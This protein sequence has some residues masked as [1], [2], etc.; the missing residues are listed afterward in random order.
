MGLI[1]VFFIS[2][3]SCSQSHVLARRPIVSIVQVDLI[4][5]QKFYDIFDSNRRWDL[6]SFCIPSLVLGDWLPQSRVGDSLG[7]AARYSTRPLI[8]HTAMRNHQDQENRT[9][10]WVFARFSNDNQEEPLRETPLEIIQKRWPF[11]LLAIATLVLLGYSTHWSQE[12]KKQMLKKHQAQQD[13][14]QSLSI[15]P[16]QYYP[17]ANALLIEGLFLVAWIYFLIR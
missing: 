17:Q 11:L 10:F 4:Q 3:S 6:N 12:R 15:F 14:S 8:C 9:G 16:N 1:L 2:L 13:P 7:S 5:R